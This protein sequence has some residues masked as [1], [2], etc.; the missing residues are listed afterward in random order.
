MNSLEIE[1]LAHKIPQIKQNFVGVFALDEIPQFFRTPAGLVVNLDRS[2][3]AGSHW[4]SLWLDQN[5]KAFYFDS[6]AQK[7]PSLISQ[8]F[9]I[10]DK[11]KRA[12]QPIM[13]TG[14]GF[15]CLL[16]L[17]L[18]N[19]HGLSMKQI[20]FFLKNRTDKE[21]EK[22]VLKLCTSARVYK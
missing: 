3:E 7:V 2:S 6:L 8:R 1:Q 14:C 21:L 18:K 15:Y 20:E 4:I 9:K 5:S 17:F 22:M 10:V 19:T 12:V 13:S 11:M 16:F